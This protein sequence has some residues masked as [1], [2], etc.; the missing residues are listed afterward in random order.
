VWYLF[1]NH[2]L[3]LATSF[4][5]VLLLFMHLYEAESWCVCR[6]IHRNIADR[7]NTLK[8]SLW[9]DLNT[10]TLMACSSFRHDKHLSVIFFSS[11]PCMMSDFGHFILKG[12]VYFT[13]DLYKT[14]HRLYE[15]T[16]GQLLKL[17]LTLGTWILS[18]RKSTSLLFA[19]PDLVNLSQMAL[20]N[21]AS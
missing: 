2:F 21:F 10:F 8:L 14:F 5:Q 20:Q 12:L 17:L 15:W 18:I 9:T 1:I 11:S 3:L 13:F 4:H 19:L 7:C 6:K 16:N